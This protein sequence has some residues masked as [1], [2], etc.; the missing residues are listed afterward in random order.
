MLPRGAAEYKHLSAQ[1]GCDSSGTVVLCYQRL[2]SSGHSS[3]DRGLRVAEVDS[4]SGL[5]LRN[6]DPCS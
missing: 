1:A 4:C 6:M 5:S 3:H 2:V